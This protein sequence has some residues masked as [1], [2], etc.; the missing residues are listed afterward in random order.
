MQNLR[1][2]CLGRGWRIPGRS[3]G[4]EEGSDEQGDGRY[5]RRL[6]TSKSPETL[7]SL[8]WRDDM[9]DCAGCGSRRLNEGGDVLEAAVDAQRGDG[10]QNEQ[11]GR[12]RE[13]R[14]R[15]A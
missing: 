11:R 5:V 15:D 10:A 13:R 8:A 12:E 7:R 9:D 6:T 2:L 4:Q 3:P 1:R 14:W